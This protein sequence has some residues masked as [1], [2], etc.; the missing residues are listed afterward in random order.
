MEDV[1]GPFNLTAPG[2]VTNRQLTKALGEVMRRPT[3]IP[4]PI[5]GIRALYGEMGVTLATASQRVVPAALTDAGFEWKHPEIL[6]PLRQAL[7]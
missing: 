5:F 7:A 1:R 2:P 4:T 3:I 6:E